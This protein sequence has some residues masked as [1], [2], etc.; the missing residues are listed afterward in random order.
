MSGERE[1][2]ES[3]SSSF[4]APRGGKPGKDGRCAICAG[5]VDDDDQ[6]SQ[7]HIEKSTRVGFCVPVV[8]R[9]IVL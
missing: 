5:L 2:E 1:E 7:E 9:K 6:F 8:G 4:G 3:S